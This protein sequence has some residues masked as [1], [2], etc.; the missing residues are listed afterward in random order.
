MMGC[1]STYVSKSNLSSIKRL[2]IC[3]VQIIPISPGLLSL[4]VGRQGKSVQ[5]ELTLK[6][7]IYFLTIMITVN[8]R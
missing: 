7:A 8:N 5:L 2:Q 3:I 6:F 4:G 1:S